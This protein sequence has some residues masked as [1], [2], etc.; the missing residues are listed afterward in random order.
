LTAHV[1]HPA[2]PSSAMTPAAEIVALELE[3]QVTTLTR[4]IETLG[5][6]TIAKRERQE[7]ETRMRAAFTKRLQELDATHEAEVMRRRIWRWPD[8]PQEPPEG[9]P[10]QQAQCQGTGL[11][12]AS[13]D[14]EPPKVEEE[15]MEAGQV[16]IAMDAGPER[17]H[18]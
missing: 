10:G 3:A 17:E 18:F 11:I 2:A 6:K 7:K 8:A 13:E 14:D 12:F 4:D 15:P 5:R 1:C 16:F 9:Q